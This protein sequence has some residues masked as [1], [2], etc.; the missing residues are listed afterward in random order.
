MVEGRVVQFLDSG[1]NVLRG[2]EF[3]AREV[4]LQ[5]W[6]S[7]EVIGM[8]VGGINILELL[9]RSCLAN[10]FGDLLALLNGDGSID[11]GG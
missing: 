10:P 1:Y 3:K 11:E 2:D 4:F 7:R 9:I 6:H 5:Y 8:C